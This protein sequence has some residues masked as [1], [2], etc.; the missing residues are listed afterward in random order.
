MFGNSEQLGSAIAR[1]LVQANSDP[2][3]QTR[4][5]CLVR[6]LLTAQNRFAEHGFETLARM[7]NPKY[8]RA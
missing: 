4:W 3:V 8:F 7:L 1:M 2:D 6:E 5:K